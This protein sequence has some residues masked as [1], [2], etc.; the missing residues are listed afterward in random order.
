[1][2]EF[3]VLTVIVITHLYKL[4]YRLSREKCLPFKKNRF[5]S[6]LSIYFLC[7]VIMY[8]GKFTNMIEVV[9]NLFRI[10]L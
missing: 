4:F 3:T 5:T 7:K 6:A 8:V 1:M 10:C 9:I 2:L